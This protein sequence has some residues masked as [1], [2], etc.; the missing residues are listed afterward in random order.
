[1]SHSDSTLEDRFTNGIWYDYGEEAFFEIQESDDGDVELV[2]PEGRFVYAEIH[3]GDWKET[4]KH[5]FRKVSDDAVENPTETVERALRM[6]LRNDIE[7]LAG[8]PEQEVIDLRYAR[9]QVEITEA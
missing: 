9:G 8:Y 2:E 1:M 6:M 7:E 4:E 5:D 3:I